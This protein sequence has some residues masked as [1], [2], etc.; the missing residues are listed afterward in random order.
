MLPGK[1]KITKKKFFQ[2]FLI[3]SELGPGHQNT[4]QTKPDL[5]QNGESDVNVTN[6]WDCRDWTAREILARGLDNTKSD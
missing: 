1:E 5:I 4:L 3:N 6:Q 2:I